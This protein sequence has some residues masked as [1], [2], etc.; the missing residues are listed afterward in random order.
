[1][2][3]TR[4]IGKRVELLAMDPH[5]QNITIALYRQDLSGRPGYLVHTYSHLEGAGDR[6]AGLR[7]TMTTL[8]GLEPSG[9]LLHF[10]CGA[11]HQAAARR[12]FL[13]AAKV[14]PGAEPPS[15]PLTVIDK[16]SQ[17]KIMAVSLGNGR[18]QITADGA[19]EGKATRVDSVAAGL[20]KLG[21][22]KAAG[23]SDQISFACGHAHDD[24][25]GLLLPRALNVRAILREEEAAAGRGLLV[26][27]SQQ[28]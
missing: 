28:K 18:Y 7:Q 6:I 17:R 23:T 21:E 19:E 26:A 3:V 13:E 10:A 14:A 1:M 9:E 2:G 15:K 8:G 24:L 16:K 5:F 12:A 22:M 4:D 25:V 20:V 27:P 11:A